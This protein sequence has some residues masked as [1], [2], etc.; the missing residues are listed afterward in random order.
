MQPI[1]K[2]NES[3]LE[4]KKVKGDLKLNQ[5]FYQYN[6]YTPYV[7]H[8]LSLHIRPGEKVV[9]TGA[10]GIGKTTLL[11]IMLGLISPSKGDILIDDIPISTL[12]FK[13]YRSFCA[14]VMQDDTLISGS[15][16]DNIAFMDNR[17][18]INRVYEVAKI[19]QI[20]DDIIKMPMNY[21]TPIGD[22]GSALSGGQKQ[23]ILIARA[24]Y[25]RPKVLFLDEATSHLDIENEIKINEGLKQ[26]NITQVSIAHREE[27]IKMA[28]RII[29][30]Q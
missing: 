12:G 4:I 26:L 28:D 7:I 20:H 19:A 30:L 15:I 8:N 17:I 5:L 9:I 25:K 29:K 16:L 6:Q 24:L 11:K 13:K 1:E 21:E 23:R 27:T 10:S 22:M 2:Q 14:S 3:R 18:D